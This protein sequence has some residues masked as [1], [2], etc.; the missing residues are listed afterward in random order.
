ML[1]SKEYYQYL[2]NCVKIGLHNAMITLAQ[3][4][5]EV[6]IMYCEKCGRKNCP[7][8]NKLE[9]PIYKLWAQAEQLDI[10]KAE[11]IAEAERLTSL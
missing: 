8:V 10:N 7:V 6:D 1:H 9:C 4:K 11:L 2:D 5:M 3:Y